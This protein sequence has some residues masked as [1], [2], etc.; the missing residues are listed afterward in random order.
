MESGRIELL[1]LWAVILISVIAVIT[2]LRDGRIYN[3][4]TIPA[5]LAG[6]CVNAWAS[7]WQGVGQS[8]LGL[9]TAL[10]SYGWL[11]ALRAMGAGDVKLL[12]AFGAWGGASF[13][14]ETAVLGVLLGG[15]VAIL[16]LIFR[17]AL[18]DFLR[19][20][21]TFLMTL[22]VK[23][24]LFEQPKLD[25]RSKIPFGVPLSAAA[26]WAYVSEPLAGLGIWGGS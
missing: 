3:W 18:P 13:S 15:G 17:G 4:L 10:L 7:G 11:Y 6:F 9:G 22:L 24:L 8:A 19:R 2:D 25:T 23:E 26:I 14:V 21:K 12:M 1:T 5:I 20:M 16:V